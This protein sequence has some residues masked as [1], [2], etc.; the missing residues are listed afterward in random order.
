MPR[1]SLVLSGSLV[2]LLAATLVAP[3][4]E[5]VLVPN[6]TYKTPG[7][8][9]RGQITSETP[10]ELKIKPATG[11]DQTIPVDQIETI[12]Y[13]GAPAAFALAESRE[14]SGQLAEAADLYKK[15]AAEATGKPFVAQAARF[16]RAS[17]L[18]DAAVASPAK[19]KEAIDDLD[20]FVQAY[21]TG[22]HST[23]ALE[24]LVRLH[25][26]NEDL[27]RA[28]AAVAALKQKGPGAAD[29]A[30]ILEAKILARSGKP[31]QALKRLD[32]LIASANG[33]PRARDA[34]LAKA[35]SLAS[36][37]RF[38]EALVIVQQVIQAAPPEDYQV[39]AVAHNTLGDCYRAARRPKDALIAYLKTDIL[40]DKNKEQH[41]RALAMIEQL[42]RELK[43]EDRAVE[44][45]ERLRQLY[46]Q[47]PYLAGGR[48]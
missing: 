14:N 40:F 3:A 41:P 36:L 37:N 25:L 32:D 29:R 19:A 26:Q 12:T 2:L 23:A 38:D 13:D 18:A 10:T 7:G 30:A 35:E 11:A 20:G 39:Q 22:R 42:F 28:G 44:V 6:A 8:R 1:R 34:Q 31:D 43:V 16:R 21:P 9:V 4:D 47:S 17:I 46:P 33:T 15:A 45:H 24:R 48:K 5:V 27:T